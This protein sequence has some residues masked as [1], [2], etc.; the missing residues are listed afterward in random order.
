M[1]FKVSYQIGR[2]RVV[3]LSNFEPAPFRVYCKKST[4]S[5]SD[6]QNGTALYQSGRNLGSKC[7]SWCSKMSWASENNDVWVSLWK[8]IQRR[9]QTL[10]ENS[11]VAYELQHLEERNDLSCLPWICNKEDWANK[12]QVEITNHDNQR[13]SRTTTYQV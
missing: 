10:R 6:R 3:L 4:W 11:P 13:L 9:S 8:T 5:T 2:V 7:Y 12:A 1:D